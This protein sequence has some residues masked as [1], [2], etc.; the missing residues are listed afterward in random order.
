MV[1]FDRVEVDRRARRLLVPTVELDEVAEAAD[2]VA[3]REGGEVHHRIADVAELEIEQRDEMAVAMVELAAVPHDRRLPT[4]TV[5]RIAAKPGE[6]ELEQRV[7][8]PFGPSVALF[9][10]GQADEARLRRGRCPHDAGVDEGLEVER[11][12]RGQR[13]HVFA[14]HGRPIRFGRVEQVRPARHS[15]HHVGREPVDPAVDARHRY[16]PLAE[17]T[18]E[19]HLVIEREDRLHVGP[20]AAHDDIADRID[21][22]EPHRSPPRL[23]AQCPHRPEL[24]LEPV[25]DNG[26]RVVHR[27]ARRGPMRSIM[28]SV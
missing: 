2:C 14:H 27:A 19:A 13:R 8:E 16:A 25:A 18:L 24:A 3:H 11:V 17:Q 9:V 22:R 1:A 21:R 20:V 26:R 23:A 6:P 4:A 10:A 12:Q 5:G 7:G 28:L 15:V